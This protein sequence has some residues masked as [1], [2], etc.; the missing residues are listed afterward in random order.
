ME[1]GKTLCIQ[2]REEWHQWLENNHNKEKEIW[3]L[4]PKISS[5]KIRIEY[6][7]AVEEALSFGWIDSTVRKIDDTYSA[8]RFSR[9]NPG[10]RYSQANIER[11]RWL[12]REGKLKPEVLDSVKN[13]L[14]EDFA[15]PEDILKEIKS[16]TAA[17][18]NFLT[19]SPA[20]IRIRI[21]YIDAARNRPEEFRKRLNYFIKMT[22]KNKMFGYGGIEKYY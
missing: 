18:K 22:E 13:I 19:F 1:L 6:N 20:Y 15:L 12:A 3:L 17:Y 7:D 8:Q 9:R 4:F 21:G 5:G 14:T 11:L 10:S 16:S 2:S